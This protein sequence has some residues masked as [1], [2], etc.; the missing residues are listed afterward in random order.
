MRRR[1]AGTMGQIW[2]VSQTNLGPA[3]P[4]HSYLSL[5]GDQNLDCS[6]CA[7]AQKAGI[8][9][10]PEGANLERGRQEK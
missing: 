4:L 8:L 10:K 3:L 7:W 2:V 9:A 6:R 5:E 1:F